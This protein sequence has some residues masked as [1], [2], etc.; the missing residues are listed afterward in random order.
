MEYETETLYQISTID[1]DVIL[2]KDVL[3]KLFEAI[4]AFDNDQAKRLCECNRIVNEQDEHGWSALIVSV[5]SSNVEM[6]QYLLK[7]GANPNVVNNNGT[8]LLM[9]AK[10]AYIQTHSNEL[11]CILKKYGLKE[12]QKDYYDRDLFYYIKE[13][14]ICIDKF[15]NTQ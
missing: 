11:Y 5:Y 15:L 10:D 8:T 2:Y 6:V 12:E 7:I 9:Y 3:E 14:G 13:D 1:Y 4:R